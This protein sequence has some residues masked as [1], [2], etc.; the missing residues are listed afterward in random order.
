L[1]EA[2]FVLG[3]AS[4][5]I[6]PEEAI[7]PPII[8]GLGVLVAALPGGVIWLA[9]RKRASRD[10]AAPIGRGEEHAGD[11]D[12]NAPDPA[13]GRAEAERASGYGQELARLR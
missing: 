2:S 4:F 6:R 8:F 5:G 13:S 12:D 3:L 10:A 9:N 11:I 1:R 7:L